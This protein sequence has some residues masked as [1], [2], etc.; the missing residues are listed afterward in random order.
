MCQYSST[1]KPRVL[2]IHPRFSQDSISVENAVHADDR[3][4]EVAAVGVPDS[5]LGELVA[6]VVSPKPTYRGQVKEAEVIE[7]VRKT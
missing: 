6:A 5:R 2:F 1:S 3:I 7:M 4:N